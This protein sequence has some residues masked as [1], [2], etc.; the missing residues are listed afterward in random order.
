MKIWHQQRPLHQRVG[1][2]Q[3]LHQHPQTLQGCQAHQLHLPAMRYKSCSKALDMVS[4]YRSV[5]NHKMNESKKLLRLK[6]ETHHTA[7]SSRTIKF[8]QYQTSYPNNLS[9]RSSTTF[10]IPAIY[11]H[12]INSKATKLCL[13]LKCL[14]GLLTLLC[15]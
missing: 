12:Q 2:L 11:Y 5:Q 6:Y 10:S 1:G 3:H 9:K 13:K 7:T 14:I 8:C 15:Y 4:K